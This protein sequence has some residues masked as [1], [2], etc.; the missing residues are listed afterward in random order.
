MYT[1]E[2]IVKLFFKSKLETKF[3]SVNYE[4]FVH[5]SVNYDCY[6][7]IVNCPLLSEL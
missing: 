5:N 6:S 2:C 7:V 3:H 1:L 4:L